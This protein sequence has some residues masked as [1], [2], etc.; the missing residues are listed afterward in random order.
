MVLEVLEKSAIIAINLLVYYSIVKL[1]YINY[2]LIIML[3]VLGIKF[4]V[5]GEITCANNSIAKRKGISKLG[6]FV[7]KLPKN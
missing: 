7:A 6:Q 2:L 5:F 3:I 1:D 4:E